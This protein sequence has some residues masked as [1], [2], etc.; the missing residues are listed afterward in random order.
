MTYLESDEDLRVVEN[1]KREGLVP[2]A[3]DNY[4]SDVRCPQS[5]LHF[6]AEDMRSIVC[7]TNTS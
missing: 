6:A 4:Y 7:R 2:Q 5:L 1:K 3:I